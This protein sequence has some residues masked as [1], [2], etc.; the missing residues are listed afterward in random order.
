[1]DQHIRSQGQVLVGISLKSLS[2]ELWISISC[3]FENLKSFIQIWIV[4]KLYHNEI[5]PTHS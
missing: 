5:P 4:F 3:Y 2:L 1:M